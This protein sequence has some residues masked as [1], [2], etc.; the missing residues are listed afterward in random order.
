MKKKKGLF[1]KIIESIDKKIEQ[2]SKCCCC[3]EKPKKK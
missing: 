1:K 3:S 2:K